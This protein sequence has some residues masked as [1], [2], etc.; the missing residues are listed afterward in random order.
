MNYIEELGLLKMDFLGLKN[1][2]VIDKIVSKV[3]VKF[4]EIPLDDKKTFDL[5]S[6]GDVD[7]VFQFESAGMRKFVSELKLKKNR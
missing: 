4:N 1:L 3:G 5:F 7:G 2:S 6:R